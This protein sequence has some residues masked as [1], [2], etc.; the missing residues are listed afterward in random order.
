MRMF[1]GHHVV[2]SPSAFE[3]KLRLGRFSHV[4]AG[5]IRYGQAEGGLIL[6]MRSVERNWAKQRIKGLGENQR[7]RTI[8]L[9][10]NSRKPA[11]ELA[12]TR[13][14]CIDEQWK[15]FFAIDERIFCEVRD[16]RLVVL[17]KL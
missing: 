12:D 3:R 13:P 5:K 10:R 8:A 4:R 11:P 15:C 9:D 7:Q 2:E 6:P 17:P 1:L 16:K 14:G